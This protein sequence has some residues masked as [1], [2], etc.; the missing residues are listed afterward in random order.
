[1]TK[2]EK[3]LSRV[4]EGDVSSITFAELKNA[5]KLKA[6]LTTAPLAA[7]KSGFIRTSTNP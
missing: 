3:T 7:T 1:M 5:L 2:K 4:L 6:S